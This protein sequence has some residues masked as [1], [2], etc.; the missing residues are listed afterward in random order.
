MFE[1][2]NI[3]K[4]VR[5]LISWIAVTKKTNDIENRITNTAFVPNRRSFNCL[6]IN[7]WALLYRKSRA[8]E[9]FKLKLFNK[10]I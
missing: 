10:L 7:I 6:K 8:E 4:P 1:K 9:I 2:K 3:A 5:P